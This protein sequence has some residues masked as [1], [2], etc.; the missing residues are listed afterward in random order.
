M[1][2]GGGIEGTEHELWILEG[3]STNSNFT[4]TSLHDLWQVLLQNST[5]SFENAFK[6]LSL[7]NNCEDIMK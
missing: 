5:L 3:L 4:T 7:G 1:V 6:N 2:E